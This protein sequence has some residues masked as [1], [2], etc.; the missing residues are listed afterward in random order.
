[1]AQRAARIWLERHARID[2]RPR[3]SELAN[4]AIEIG[5]VAQH[6]EKSPLPVEAVVAAGETLRRNLRREHAVLARARGIERL[7][8]RPEVHAD[9]G[10]QARRDRQHVCQLRL[11]Q[12]HQLACRRRGAEHA[13]RASAVKAP[14]V[15]VRIDG[16]SHLA[17]DLD[18]RQVRFK[19]RRA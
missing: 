11:V 10:R 6:L 16:L 4:Q 19:E 18:A 8:H 5:A 15:M 2:D 13:E 12:F 9:T 7:A 17:L 3:L 1:M 14:L